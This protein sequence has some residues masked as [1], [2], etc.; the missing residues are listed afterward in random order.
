MQSR[1][2][3]N[4][5][6]KKLSSSW[7]FNVIKEPARFYGE[8]KFVFSNL[9]RPQ[10]GLQIS[11]MNM[12]IRY[13]ITQKWVKSKVFFIEGHFY[14][15]KIF[16]S[17]KTTSSTILKHYIQAI[18]QCNTNKYLY[19]MLTEKM[20]CMHGRKWVF[21]ELQIRFVNAFDPIKC[22]KQIK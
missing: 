5:E 19:Q 8:Y 1:Y 13:K 9:I 20:P 4:I 6:R 17:K 22:L 11:T 10:V 3:I 18:F 12:N 14:I 16:P 2:S 7:F 21:S 15:S